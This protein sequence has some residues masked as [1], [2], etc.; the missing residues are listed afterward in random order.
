MPKR[1]ILHDIRLDKIA[2]VD[3][4][5]Q[6]HARAVLMKRR[7]PLAELLK[8]DDQHARGFAELLQEREAQDRRWEAEEEMWPI[9]SAL[10]E[11]L[12]SILGDTALTDEQR[13]TRRDESIQQFVTAI[14]SAWPEVAAEIE[15]IAKAKP[16]QPF[17]AALLKAGLAGDHG[18]REKTM[19]KTHEEKIAD[20]EKRVGELETELDTAKQATSAAEEERDTEKARAD[21]AE[22]DLAKAR[23]ASDET[24]TIKNG[25]DE[26]VVKRSEVGDAQFTVLKAQQ[27]QIAKA[28]ERAEIAELSKRASTEFPHVAGTPDEIAK[29]LRVLK[30][31]PEDVRDAGE[32]ILKAAEAMSRAGFERLGHRGED[33][34]KAADSF[35]DRVV[36]IEKRDSI[37]RHKAMTKARREYPEE[38]QAYQEAQA[39]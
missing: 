37:P 2:A 17:F 29:V 12:S 25:D 20:L 32:A 3:F 26:T 18:K 1:R 30:T 35:N 31:A 14:N 36:E 15:K 28:D 34:R 9:F 4:P 22:S 10:R 7:D 6:E 23:E 19:P 24:L 16:E 38:F 5:C 11:S 8:S 39:N 33:V 13:T 27:A 21:E